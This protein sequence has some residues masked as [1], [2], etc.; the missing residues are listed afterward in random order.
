MERQDKLRGQKR[1]GEEREKSLNCGSSYVSFLLVL[2]AH[3]FLA[4]RT[5]GKGEEREIL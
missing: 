1:K 4:T 5:K 3:V 2:F